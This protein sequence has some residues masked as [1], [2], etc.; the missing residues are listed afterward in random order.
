MK[1]IITMGPKHYPGTLLFDDVLNQAT[2]SQIQNVMDTQDLIQ[3]DDPVNIQF[4]SVRF[5]YGS[6]LKITYFKMELCDL[7]IIFN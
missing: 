5:L 4:T 7:N 3:F 6:H 2:P 1:R